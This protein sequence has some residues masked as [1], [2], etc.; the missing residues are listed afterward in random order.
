[1]QRD[2]DEAFKKLVADNW[3]RTKKDFSDSIDFIDNFFDINVIKNIMDWNEC[4]VVERKGSAIYKEQQNRSK[5]LSSLHIITDREI[6]QNEEIIENRSILVFDDSIKEG[7]TIRRILDLVSRYKPKDV[8]VAT[9]IA[10]EDALS[11]LRTDYPKIKFC[12]A[13]EVSKAD[14]GTIYTK[15]I[16]PYLGYICS[17]LQ[18]DHP[19]L[20]IKF[21]KVPDEDTIMRFFKLYGEVS[22]DKDWNFSNRLKS[23]F[24]LDRTFAQQFK[25]LNFIEKLGV[26]EKNDLIIKV[27]MYLKKDNGRSTL[28]LQPMILEGFNANNFIKSSSIKLLDYHIKKMFLL[29]FLVEKF[30]LDYLINTEAG[31]SNFSVISD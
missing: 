11:A 26:L 7:K 27:K 6:T 23:S 24:V 17:P 19:R 9:L 3:P 2:A 8:A 14:F 22:Y 31:F 1:M 21:L 10:R 29:E 20:I 16:F 18:N 12:S 28:T 5:L 15:R 13:S 30:L 25:I 4:I